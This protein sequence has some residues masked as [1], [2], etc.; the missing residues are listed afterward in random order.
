MWRSR[1]IFPLPI[2]AFSLADV[3]EDHSPPGD[4]GERGLYLRNGRNSFKIF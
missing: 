2:T 3:L 1:D 4:N